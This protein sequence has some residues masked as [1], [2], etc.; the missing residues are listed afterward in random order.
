[1]PQALL[2]GTLRL[3]SLSAVGLPQNLATLLF[4]STLTAS[5]FQDREVRIGTTISDFLISDAHFSNMQL[6]YVQ[7]DQIIRVNWG[8]I[9]NNSHISLA[10]AGMQG[11]H[12]LF[13]GSAISGPNNIHLGQSGTS[14][15]V[16]R[17]IMAQ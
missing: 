8:G 15:A 10:S 13:M 11:T 4:S 16:C 2:S 6:A 17:V 12:H 14:E 3:S 9:G 1:M 5:V 7:S